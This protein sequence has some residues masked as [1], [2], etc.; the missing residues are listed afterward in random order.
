MCLNYKEIRSESDEEVEF[1]PAIQELIDDADSEPDE[2][3]V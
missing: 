2:F 1:S 3:P